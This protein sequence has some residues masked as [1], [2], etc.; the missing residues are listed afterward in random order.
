M[1]GPVVVAAAVMAAVVIGATATAAGL[2]VLREQPVGGLLGFDLDREAGVEAAE[3]AGDALEDSG[4]VDAD[5]YGMTRK[6]VQGC[7]LCG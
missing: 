7:G 2:D 1:V 4:G 3:A 6:W 5:P